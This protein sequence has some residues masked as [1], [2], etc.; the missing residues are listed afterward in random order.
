MAPAKNH[1]W[2]AEWRRFRTGR[3][4]LDFAHTGGEGPRQRF[5]LLHAPEDLCEWLAISSLQLRDVHAD[6]DDLAC[7]KRLREAIWQSAQRAIAGRTAGCGDAETI[8]ALA[9]YPPLAPVLRSGAHAWQWRTPAP[10]GAALSTIA[11]DA[12]ELFG[13]ASVLRVRE[14]AS[15]DCGLLFFD[16]SRPGTR[17][18]C[19]MSRCGN[20]AKVGRYR[21]RLAG[22]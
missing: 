4:C 5:E 11:R 16:D 22:E 1:R 12:I 8:N 18:W 15:P 20:R 21:R 14:C 9:S 13:S 19:S 7:A 10:A 3:L 17:R 6:A 2:A